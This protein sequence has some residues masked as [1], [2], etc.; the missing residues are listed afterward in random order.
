MYNNTE[1]ARPDFRHAACH[2]A[3]LEYA[4]DGHMGYATPLGSL[5]LSHDKNMEVQYEKI[6]RKYGKNC[7]DYDN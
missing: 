2:N 4:R 7:Y 1:G 3:A 5:V 6:T